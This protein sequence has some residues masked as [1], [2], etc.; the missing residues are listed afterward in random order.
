M[1]FVFCIYFYY[2]YVFCIYLCFVYI[3]IL[4]ICICIYL[5]FVYICILYICICIYLCSVYICILDIFVFWI[6]LC[7]VY[8]C[9][10]HN[11]LNFRDLLG[12]A[13]WRV[14]TELVLNL[15]SSLSPGA[16]AFNTYSTY[17]DQGALN[18]SVVMSVGWFRNTSGSIQSISWK[19][20][21]YSGISI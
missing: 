2:V 8:I 12:L 9:V 20:T 4:N 7:F 5:Y 11:Y 18:T 15:L 14:E 16:H 3:C 1:A 17:F 13:D 19:F 21:R 10:G 6:Y